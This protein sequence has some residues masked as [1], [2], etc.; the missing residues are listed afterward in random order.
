MRVLLVGGTG[1]LGGHVSAALL[2]AG[3]EVAVIS[4][5]RH[6]IPA[7]VTHLEADRRDVA[8][9]GGLLEG[10]R[11]DFTVDFT[12]FEAAD[13]ERLL[14]IP[15]A[16]LGRYVL[17]SS[18]Q[19]YLVTEGARVPSPEEDSDRP[20]IREPEPG[21]PDHAQWLYGVGKRRAEGALLALREMH[22]VRGVILRLPIIQGEGDGS[23]RLWAY[24][25]RMLDGGP[26]VLPDGGAR[27]LRHVYAGDV[28]RGV[29]RLAEQPKPRFP[30]YNLA[31]ADIVTLREFLARV[32]LAAGLEPRFVDASWAEIEAAGIPADFSP[33]GG[34]WASVPDPA[35]AAEWGFAGSRVA[36]YLPGV[37]RW[38]LAHRPAASHAGY[39]HRA[40]ELALAARLSAAAS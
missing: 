5:G 38:H 23:L 30:I 15:Y 28:A 13:V 2:E 17:I 25:E 33:Y 40:A 11:F 21:T 34:R 19:V 7:G 4:R 24:L 3:H 8:A 35:R 29:V 39:A 1:F 36:D 10:R 31:Q 27:P 16:A 14:L 6:P 26:I 22:G 32:A 9:L 12:A 18:G 37:V 20:L